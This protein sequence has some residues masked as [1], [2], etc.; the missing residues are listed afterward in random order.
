MPPKLRDA[1]LL[2]TQQAYI[3]AIQLTKNEQK[4][5]KLKQIFDK[6]KEEEKA[7]RSMTVLKNDLIDLMEAGIVPSDDASKYFKKYKQRLIIKLK[8]VID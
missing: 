5:L 4:K 2:Q 8:G 7:R 6:R 1:T 3:R